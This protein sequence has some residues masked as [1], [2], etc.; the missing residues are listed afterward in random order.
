M[1]AQ[2]DSLGWQGTADNPRFHFLRA[3]GRIALLVVLLVYGFPGNAAPAPFLVNIVIEND[4]DANS[5][6]TVVNGDR[7]KVSFEVIDPE[8]LLNKGD[9]IQLLR[10][11]GNSIVSSASRG[12]K[13]SGSVSLPV[14]KTADEALYVRYIRKGK[15]GQVLDIV[16]H[17]DDPDHVPLLSL[18]KLNSAELTR[19]LY[20][21]EIGKQRRV[22][23]E[24]TGGKAIG[25]IHSDGTVD[26]ATGAGLARTLIVSPAGDGS[27]SAQNGAALLDALD[28][29]GSVIPAPGAT[30]PWLI[31][32]EPGIYDIGTTVLNMMPHVDIEGSGLYT[33]RIKGEQSGGPGVVILVN[34][35]ELRFLTVENERD[36]VV[37]VTR[38]VTVSGTSARMTHVRVI[39]LGTRGQALVI[40]SNQEATVRDSILIGDQALGVVGTGNI[41]STQLDGPSGAAGLFRCLG[42]FDENFSPLDS[43]CK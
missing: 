34:N 24:C 12:R 5:Q 9:K 8:K 37:Q 13:N 17:P 42:V 32:I 36:D 25:K 6:I 29:L 22:S 19:G 18:A 23:E 27:D 39:S 40:L 15:D 31:K 7:V 2:F 3:M 30:N 38:G 28:F 16:S 26:C 10:V 33:T 21:A 4:M 43:A 1:H 35:A 41:I 20:A 11:D 14:K